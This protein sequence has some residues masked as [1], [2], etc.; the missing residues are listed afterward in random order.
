MFIIKCFT[1][2]NSSLKLWQLSITNR[3]FCFP[4]GSATLTF[5][6]F[7]GNPVNV[8]KSIEANQILL[9]LPKISI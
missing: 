6:F 3:K 5:N 8:Q 9:L 7:R 2:I 4:I 1:V